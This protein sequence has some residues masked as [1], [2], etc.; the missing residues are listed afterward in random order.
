LIKFTLNIRVLRGLKFL[1]RSR[2]APEKFKPALQ[3]GPDPGNKVRGSIS[4]TFAGQVS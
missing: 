4:V 2:P 3:A 1:A